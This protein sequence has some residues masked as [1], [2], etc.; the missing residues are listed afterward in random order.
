MKILEKSTMPDGTKIQLEDWSEHNTEEYPDLYGLTIGA[1]PIAKN[2]GKYE[3]VKGGR[4]FRL[5]ISKN[6]YSGY[7]NDN[8][9]ADFEALKNGE[10]KLEDLS[11]HFWYGEKDAWYLG[12][13]VEY[14]GW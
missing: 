4:T 13:D 1:Y 14:K 2:T 10:K 8:V 12:M 3:W 9:K 11:A 7:T 5:S 6:K